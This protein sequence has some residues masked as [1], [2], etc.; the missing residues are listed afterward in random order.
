MMKSTKYQLLEADFKFSLS[1]LKDYRKMIEQL[2]AENE[3]LKK[4][5]ESLMKASET[6]S[7]LINEYEDTLREID[8][9]LRSTRNPI[10][11][12]VEAL[13]KSLPEYR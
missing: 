5:K 6:R 9:H 12:I 10:P 13:K 8:T 2:R 7:K 4:Y 3:V 1:L 11:Y